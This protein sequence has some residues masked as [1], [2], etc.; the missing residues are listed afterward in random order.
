MSIEAERVR[1]I[2]GAAFL[3]A[4]DIIRCRAVLRES[5]DFFVTRALET[6][7]AS[8]A[9]NVVSRALWQRILMTVERAFAPNTRKDDRHVRVAFDDLAKPDVFEEVAKTGSRKHLEQA[10]AIWRSYDADPRRRKLRHYRDKVIAHVGKRDPAIPVPLTEELRDYAYGTAD[11]LAR[12]ARGASS[13]DLNLQVQ[14]KA[15][16]ESAKAFWAV[17]LAPQRL[18]QMPLVLRRARD[19]RA[20]AG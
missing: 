5:E 16:E 13:V 2:A 18:T 17:W 19:H 8:R 3:D 20:S 12:L 14:I 10:C 4:I 15:Y 9:A 7:N 6:A 11:V 1:Q